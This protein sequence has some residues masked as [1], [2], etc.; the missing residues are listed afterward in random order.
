MYKYGSQLP[1]PI[2]SSMS[3]TQKNSTEYTVGIPLCRPLPDPYI[4]RPW[5]SLCPGKQPPPE[6]MWEKKA[7]LASR[8]A[9]SVWVN[10][11][12]LVN[13]HTHTH[14]L[15]VYQ[16]KNQATGECFI[17]VWFSVRWFSELGLVHSNYPI[18]YGQLSSVIITEG[19]EKKI[20]EILI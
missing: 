19:R 11:Q 6:S 14:T 10:R 1:S 9:K 12:S 2:L 18:T 17:T 3:V 20:T 5:Y 16:H 4:G 15:Q 7:A 8:L 13:T